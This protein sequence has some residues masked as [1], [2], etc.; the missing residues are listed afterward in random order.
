MDAASSPLKLLLEIIPM[1]EIT[2][3]DEKLGPIYLHLHPFQKPKQ[4]DLELG[5]EVDAHGGSS[6]R[7]V[8]LH[9]W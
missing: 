8:W 4:I 7:R 6:R 3:E 5:A 2:G 1:A 9:R